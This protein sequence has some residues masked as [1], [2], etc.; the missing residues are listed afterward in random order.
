LLIGLGERLARGRLRYPV[1]TPASASRRKIVLISSDPAAA[2]NL[3]L[4]QILILFLLGVL[5]LTFFGLFEFLLGQK[6][7]VE[8]NTSRED[9]K[10]QSDKQ[11]PSICATRK[12]PFIYNRYSAALFQII[13]LFSGISTGPISPYF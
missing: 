10:L 1:V 2:G 9:N 8:I 4:A 12:H 11:M 13:F 6:E 7:G 5:F 3:S